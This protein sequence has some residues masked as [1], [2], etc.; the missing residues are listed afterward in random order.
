MNIKNKN[1]L[2]AAGGIIIIILG[3]LIFSRLYPS[4]STEN[5]VNK[6]TIFNEDDNTAPIY[7]PR[8]AVNATAGAAKEQSLAK[9]QKLSQYKNLSDFNGKEVYDLIQILE[10]LKLDMD[11]FNSAQFKNLV[12]YTYETAVSEEEKGNVNPF[13][14]V[15]GAFAEK[16]ISAA[17]TTSGAE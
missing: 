15:K 4:V 10:K 13:S 12:D 6:E 14:S 9:L 7:T 5:T 1:A 11:F 2:F 3:Y 8:T 16:N 17:T